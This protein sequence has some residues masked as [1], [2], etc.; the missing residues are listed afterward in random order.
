MG[1]T[2][3]RNLLVVAAGG[4]TAAMSLATK[5]ETEAQT[6]D[7]D[8]HGHSD[9]P[10][11]GPLAEATV[12]FGQWPADSTVD[13]MRVANPGNRNTH[14]IIPNEVTIQ[15]GGA[16]DFV[17]AGFHQIV[18]YDNGTQPGDINAA[19][20]YPAPLANLI[21]DPN[22]R[23]YVGLSPSGVPANFFILS[24]ILLQ[25]NCRRENGDRS[26]L[27]RGPEWIV[28]DLNG[29]PSVAVHGPR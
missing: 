11:S 16:V 20:A 12:S 8:S 7:A 1:G 25:A 21:N 10:I 29:A 27:L 17:V 4:V 9:K 13:R 19:L 28:I 23:I 6:R 14:V 26:E 3:R 18:I 5:S 15:A 24:S 2:T 22:R